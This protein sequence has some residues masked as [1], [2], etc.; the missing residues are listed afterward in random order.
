M[1]EKR[2]GIPNDLITIK[3]A[4][5]LVNNTHVNTIRHWIHKKKLRAYRDGTCVSR[6]A[7]LAIMRRPSS[8]V[9]NQS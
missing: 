6:G 2:D 7:V 4:A 9:E 8:R 1:K 5:R 3:H